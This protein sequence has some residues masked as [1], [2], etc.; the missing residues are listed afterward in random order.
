MQSP[1]ATRIN[2][3]V[4]AEI[5][6]ACTDSNKQ[7]NPPRS[8]HV[9]KIILASLFVTSPFCS[10]AY[11]GDKEPTPVLSELRDQGKSIS[12]ITPIFSQLLMFSVPKGFTPVFE[13]NQGIQYVQEYVLEGQSTKLWSQMLSISGAKNLANLPN[14]SPQKFID[15]M[16]NG[17][18]HD[19]PDSFNS[20]TL[21]TMKIDGFDA[22]ASILS[23]GIAMPAAFP[24]SESALIVAVQGAKDYYTI[25]WAERGAASKVALAIDTA[26]WKDRMNKVNPI[27][28][29]PIVAGEAAP[30]ASCAERK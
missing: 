2:Y 5:L 9:K 21:G 22:Y 24:Y 4:Q 19:C 27:R 1:F 20:V 3:D 23:C 15:G 26:L 13:K 8:R 17:F 18:K 28:L 10:V 14:I 6:L 11:A 7:I 29:C 30:Y 25:Q 16:A 12:S